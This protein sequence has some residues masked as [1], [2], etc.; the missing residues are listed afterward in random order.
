MSRTVFILGAGASAMAGAPLMS[1]FIGDAQTVF[2]EATNLTEADRAAFDLVFKART[3][4]QSVHSKAALQLNNIEALFGAFEMAR[5][6][7]KLGNLTLGEIGR[8]PDSIVR[9]ITRTLEHSIQLK[10][11]GTSERPS[12]EPARPYGDF[13]RL[14]QDMMEADRRNAVSVLTFNYDLALDQALFR[15]GIP[16]TYRLEEDSNEGV[17]LLKLH[18]SLNWTRCPECKKVVPYHLREY[19]GNHTSFV[20]LGM[21]L[22][23]DVSRR[24]SGKLHCG[25]HCCSELPVIVP[26]T[27]NKGQHHSQLAS[28][29]RRAA[30]HLAEAEHVFI[31][32]YSLPETDEF[33]RYLYALGSVGDAILSCVWVVD[34]SAAVGDAFSKI[35]GTQAVECYKPFRGRFEES[36][37]QIRQALNLRSKAVSG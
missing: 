18:G 5:L 33:F 27:W 13:V 23:I 36:I 20:S 6:L 19:Y 8:L 1:S 26:P 34:P 12:I 10:V 25:N 4:I 17:D 21:R 30:Y 37:P 22:V 24:L 7:G 31:I 9:V 32:G 16:F 14:L 29:W 3:Q 11:V 15:K 35:F 2:R 28:V